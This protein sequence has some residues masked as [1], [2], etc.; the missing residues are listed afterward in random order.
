MAKRPKG[1][2]SLSH[3]TGDR[4]RGRVFIRTD[5]AT[6]KPIQL[7][8][9]IHARTKAEAQRQ[10]AAFIVEVQADPP[11][12]SSATVRTTVE[13]WIRHIEA[14]GRAPRTIEEA[15]RTLEREIGP[16]L[17]AIPVGKL[18][19]RDVDEW[20]GRM[21][22]GDGRPRPLKPSTIT[23]H[24]G[25]LRAALTQAVTWEWIERNPVARAELPR[26]SRQAVRV[27]SAEDVRRLVLAAD[28]RDSTWGLLVRL[29]VLTGCR[30]GELC[31]LRWEDVD[32]AAGVMRI[33]RSIYRAG[34]ATGIKAPKSGRERIVP[35]DPVTEAV[36][37]E[38]LAQ[39]IDTAAEID[40]ELRPDAYVASRWPDGS[41]PI[42]PDTFTS[43]VRTMAN[44][45]GLPHVHLHSL[46]HFA[47]TELLAAG[48][49]PRD[50][51]E[52]LGH[53]D[54][55]RLALAT[56]SHATDARQRAAAAVLGRALMPGE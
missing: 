39:A 41:R 37:A 3:V 42:N 50:T 24:V 1:T 36:L 38:R 26:T 29:A 34:G 17:G 2:G 46:R 53:A 4:W 13:E 56:Y 10:L 40:V 51:A 52:L 21:S 31:G 45:L 14:R 54:G 16:A 22:T 11:A 43:A 25:V 5:R 7:E 55:G 27:P 33:R 23:R 6:G 19:T 20:I 49:S 9:T 44:E 18:S 12:G 30:R 47:A 35:L 8:R 15:R 28:E 48:I 32:T